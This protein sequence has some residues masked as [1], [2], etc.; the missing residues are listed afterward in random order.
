MSATSVCTIT[1]SLATK[2]VTYSGDMTIREKVGVTVTGATGAT[3][4]GLLMRVLK[5][6]D[7][8]EMAVCDAFTASGSDF[9]GTL[10]LSGTAL[11]A[12]FS[13]DD[14]MKKRAFILQF[15]NLTDENEIITDRVYIMNNVFTL[16]LQNTT[17]TPA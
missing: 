10:D 9:V 3:A 11:A 14:P 15:F 12:E 16:A 8:V 6:D 2:L 4:A 17:L 5:P 13:G 1:V 7:Q